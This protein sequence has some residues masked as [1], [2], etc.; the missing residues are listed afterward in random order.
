MSIAVEDKSRA[1]ACPV[2]R[3]ET[4]RRNINYA[5]VIRGDVDSL[6]RTIK[7]RILRRSEI[8]REFHIRKRSSFKGILIVRA[9]SYSHIKR[10]LHRGTNGC[11]RKAHRIVAVAERNVY[12]LSSL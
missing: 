6:Q 12:E 5:P 2:G 1:V 4:F 8:V 11:S 9:H 10:P 7:S 3:L